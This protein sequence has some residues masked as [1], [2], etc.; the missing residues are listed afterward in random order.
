MKLEA[1]PTMSAR[2][3]ARETLVEVEGGHTLLGPNKRVVIE[4]EVKIHAGAP[5]QTHERQTP[6]V[7]ARPEINA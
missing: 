5:C 6:V 3:P 4:R 1:G 2:N 7:I